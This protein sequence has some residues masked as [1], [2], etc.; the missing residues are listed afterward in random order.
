MKLKIV[1]TA[2]CS[3]ILVSGVLAQKT[4]P[5]NFSGN[6]TL[7]LN[8]S[9]LKEHLPPKSLTMTVLQTANTLK[10]E[11]ETKVKTTAYLGNGKSRGGGFGGR[12]AQIKDVYNYSL[13]GK[14]T[15]YQDTD[16]IGNAQLNAEIE[17][18]GQLKL[19]QTRRFN[20]PGGEKLLKT[21][22]VWTLSPDGK[23]LTIKKDTDVLKGD[24]VE[25]TVIVETSEMRFTKI[26]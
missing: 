13:N 15:V 25:K 14:Q 17:K 24:F 9:K 5:G 3:L 19:I 22:E 11:T 21:I 12:P 6:W 26:K 1:L 4:K 18:T 10:I 7:D 2:I 23:T 20:M 16:G 8:K